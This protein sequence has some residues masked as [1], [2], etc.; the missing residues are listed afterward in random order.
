LH[1]SLWDCVDEGAPFGSDEGADAYAE[2]VEWLAQNP[3]ENLAIFLANLG[4]EYNYGDAFTFDATVIA[5]V[6]GQLVRIGRIDADAKPYARKS[7][8][9]QLAETDDRER[10][11]F[12]TRSLEAIEAG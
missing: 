6:L 1:E 9:R 5:S 7:V 2:V 10:R 4:E 11:M 12:L 8:Q 3:N